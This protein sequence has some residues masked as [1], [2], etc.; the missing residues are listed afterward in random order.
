[1]E[2]IPHNCRQSFYLPVEMLWC[3]ILRVV[4]RYLRL[5][6]LLKFSNPCILVLHHTLLY[7]KESSTLHI[8]YNNNGVAVYFTLS[9]CSHGPTSRVRTNGPMYISSC[10]NLR[11]SQLERVKLLSTQFSSPVS[12]CAG[13]FT[14]DIPRRDRRVA[15]IYLFNLTDA[16]KICRKAENTLRQKLFKLF[17]ALRKIWE[18]ASL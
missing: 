14:V 10:L 3:F 17:M 7:F 1:M 12:Y 5:S 11:V 13:I 2:K 6:Q 18:A 4:R 15:S 16:T 8:N 9:S